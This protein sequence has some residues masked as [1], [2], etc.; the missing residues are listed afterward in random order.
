M[1]TRARRATEP[2]ARTM[3]MNAPMGTGSFL[4][5]LSAAVALNISGEESARVVQDAAA[6]KSDR[7]C[8]QK[9]YIAFCAKGV[10]DDER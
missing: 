9:L 2:R 1:K 8:F 7:A 10:Q 4:Y 3:P 6:E 5:L